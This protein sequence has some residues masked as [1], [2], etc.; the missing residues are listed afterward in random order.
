MNLGGMAFAA[1]CLVVGGFLIVF[2]RRIGALFG[3]MVRPMG[4]DQYR[5][6]RRGRYPRVYGIGAAA[7]LMGLLAAVLSAG[8]R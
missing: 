4:F 7:V 3:D 1:G 8:L 6:D 5:S 2:N